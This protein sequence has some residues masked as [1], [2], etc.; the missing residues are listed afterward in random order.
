LGQIQSFFKTNQPKAAD[1][2]TT[3]A[4]SDQLKEVGWYDQNSHSETKEIGQRRP[5]ELG[6]YDMSGNV[7]EWCQDWYDRSFYATCKKQGTVRDPVNE[8][9]G[10]YR[11]DRGGSW[12]YDADYCRVSLRHNWLP[13]NRYDNIGFRLVLAPVQ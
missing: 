5:N 12:I 3:Y 6:L 9:E 13:T 11:V 1:L 7:Y 2:Y 8:E 10:L 4:G